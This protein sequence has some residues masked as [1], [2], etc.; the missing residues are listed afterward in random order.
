M[1]IHAVVGSPNF[2]IQADFAN[3]PP[4]VEI[5]DALKKLYPHTHLVSAKTKEFNEK[6]EH[7]SFDFDR[8][9]RMAEDSGFMGIYSAEQWAAKNNPADF[10][11]ASDWMFEHLKANIR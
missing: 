1:K 8:C 6:R 3:F 11:K 5:Y 7:T 9:V 2:R 4:E 10:E